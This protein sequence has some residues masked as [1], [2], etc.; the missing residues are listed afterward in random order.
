MACFKPDGSLT[1]LARD[2]LNLIDQ[3]RGAGVIAK[4]LDHPLFLVRSSLRE[5]IAARLVEDLGDQ[6]QITALGIEK[7]A[8]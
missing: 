4:E 3:P 8:H 6:Y 1:A 2:L 7:R 5:L